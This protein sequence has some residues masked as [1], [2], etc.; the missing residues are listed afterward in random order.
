M[1]NDEENRSS[2][3]DEGLDELEEEALDLSVKRAP[4]PSNDAIVSSTSLLNNNINNNKR[5]NK[6]I[7][8]TTADETP[9]LNSDETTVLTEDG[10]KTNHNHNNIA[11]EASP[12]ET[13]ES[14][15]EEEEEIEPLVDDEIRASSEVES[16]GQED[17]MTEEIDECYGDSGGGPHA[18]AIEETPI[19]GLDE[20]AGDEML[21]NEEEEPEED[22][23]ARSSFVDDN[24]VYSSPKITT[25][26][27]EKT[28]H[29]HSS[30]AL[31]KK[32]KRRSTVII[33]FF[34][35]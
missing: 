10:T 22:E 29:H 8:T 35:F 30:A 21:P 34:F 3:T 13:G 33:T 12:D 4:P 1:S 31:E 9:R 18:D 5:K 28:R 19:D 14:H 15:V 20:S 2:E 16:F 32:L 23:D 6:P 17:M 25:T 26:F 7:K 27:E 11:D 24:N